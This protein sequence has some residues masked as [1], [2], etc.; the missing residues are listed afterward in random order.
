[1]LAERR[2]LLEHADVELRAVPPGET[3]QLDR[4]CQTRGP[5]SDDQHIQLHPIA[6]A[7]CAY[8]DEELVQRQGR[9]VLRRNQPFPLP[10]PLTH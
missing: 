5:G 3:R 8:G 2:G 10:R 7:R 4:R 1:M 6:R 9:L